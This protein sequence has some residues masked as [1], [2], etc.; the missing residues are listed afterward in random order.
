MLARTKFLRGALIC[1]FF[2]TALCLFAGA[3][4][5]EPAPRFNATTTT[6]EKFT[7]ASVKGK[8]SSSGKPAA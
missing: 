1:A 5:K 3:N 7:N 4:D 2:L 6:G 8:A